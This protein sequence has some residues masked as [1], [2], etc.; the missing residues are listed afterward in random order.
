MKF[1]L[2]GLGNMAASWPLIERAVPEADRLGFWGAVFPDHYMWGEDRGGNATL[3]TWVALS[4]LAART[5]KIR[6]GTQVTPLQFR[7]PGM[8]AKMV[9]TVDVISGGRAI[10]GVGA[11]WSQTEFEGYSEW[12]EPR[13]RVDK[14]IEGLSLVLSLWTE[15]KP[16]NFNGKFYHAKEAVLQPKPVQKPHPPLLFGSQGKRMLRL[17]G[18]Q[19]NICLL[20]GDAYEESKKVVLDEAKARGRQNEISFA[21]GMAGRPAKY[22]RKAWSDAAELARKKGC[23]YMMVSFP[24][25]TCVESM[26]DFAANV[27]PSFA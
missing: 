8:L 5:T 11:G 18:R 23:D 26:K 6:L 12:N 22:D 4:N 1:I 16:L 14:V 13:V 9:S 25:D 27:M 21:T 15:S 20:Q 19:G 7:P 10:L 2:A 17:T 3:E 24:A